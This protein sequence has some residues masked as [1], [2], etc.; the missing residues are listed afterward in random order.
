MIGKK[1]NY[2]FFFIFFFYK[3]KAKEINEASAHKL[4]I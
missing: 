4:A 3:K 2:Y 1:K